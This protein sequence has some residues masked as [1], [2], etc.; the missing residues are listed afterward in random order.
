MKSYSSILVTGLWHFIEKLAKCATCT[1]SLTPSVRYCSHTG[2][3]VFYH[4]MG[5]RQLIGKPARDPLAFL[6]TLSRFIFSVRAD[7]QPPHPQWS[8]VSITFSHGY[9][10]FEGTVF[11]GSIFIYN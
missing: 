6:Q 5:S 1:Y 10:E 7:V 9:Q 11:L 8:L 3:E 2:K 4:Y